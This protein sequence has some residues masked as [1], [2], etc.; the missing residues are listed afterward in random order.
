MRLR[1][2]AHAV[3]ETLTAESDHHAVCLLA[4]SYRRSQHAHLLLMPLKAWV[5][6]FQAA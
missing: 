5:E 2:T 4:T 3:T 1:S 6:K